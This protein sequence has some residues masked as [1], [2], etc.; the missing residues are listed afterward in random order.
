MANRWRD[1]D[2]YERGYRGDYDR[3]AAAR[4]GS[5]DYRAD[6]ESGHRYGQMSNSERYRGQERSTFGGSGS[7]PDYGDYARSDS[8]RYGRWSDEN[9]SGR[10]GRDDG[11]R[12]SER[13]YGYPNDR[14]TT[15]VEYERGRGYRYGGYD[16]PR[17]AGS[18]GD[19]LYGDRY[20][21]RGR[22]DFGSSYR[23]RSDQDRGFFDR[24]GDEVRSWFG[25]EDAERRRNMDQYRG[26]GPK[27]Y[28]RSDERIR[29]DVCDRLSDDP[30]VDASE[31][32][33]AVA[34]GEVTLTGMV[35]D[36]Y[37]KRRA[38]DVADDISGVKNVQNNIR[39]QNGSTG[40]GLGTGSGFGTSSGTST[41]TGTSTGQLGK[42][43]N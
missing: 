12:S 41:S 21:A 14:G 7:G 31:I 6:E 29:E 30:S 32:E 22:D 2:R 35:H 15:G 42:T 20:G 19:S 43:T 17:R 3:D 4:R 40:S 33:V 27:G 8:E 34:N 38:E 36:R 13:G 1:D 11:W 18:F 16:E 9:Q 28:A 37:A 26:H 39:V 5:Q 24:A 25:D 23:S 10:Y